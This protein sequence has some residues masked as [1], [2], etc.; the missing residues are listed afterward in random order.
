MKPFHEAYPPRFRTKE[1][2]LLYMECLHN[3]TPFPAEKMIV[4]R[5]REGNNIVVNPEWRD[6]P[7]ERIFL[8][9]PTRVLY[10]IGEKRT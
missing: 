1:D 8:D 10:T 7:F 6:A 4:P 9:H 3:H 5:I 2:A